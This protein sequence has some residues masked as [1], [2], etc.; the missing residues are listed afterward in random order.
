M[1]EK[2]LR[3]GNWIKY[4]SGYFYQ[5]DMIY[6]NYRMLEVWKP[7]KI[8]PKILLNCGFYFHGEDCDTGDYYA[9][10]YKRKGGYGE[11]NILI[12]N[13][14]GGVQIWSTNIPDEGVNLCKVKYLH[15]LQNLYFS[16]AKK[17]LEI[18]L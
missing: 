3:I 16:L 1:N 10:K 5:V 9:I 4:P 17:E 12:I 6:K 15:E 18:N 11:K 2:D 14:L 7:I 8:T 13:C